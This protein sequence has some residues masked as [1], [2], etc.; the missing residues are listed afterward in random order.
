MSERIRPGD[1]SRPGRSVQDLMRALACAAVVSAA[2]C[3]LSV[4]AAASSGETSE[5]PPPAA[6]G[7]TPDL[8]MSFATPSAT[9]VSFDG[10]QVA[11]VVRTPLMEGK[12]SEWVSRIW[13]AAAD[14]SSNKQFTRGETSANAPAFSPD[15]RWLAFTAARG[16]EAGSS[17]T[18]QIWLLPM[19]GGEARQLTD[20]AS[21]VDAF[22]WSPD[23]TRIA[24]LTGDPDTPQEKKKK[25][26]KRAVIL[27]D[28]D[29]KMAR[30]HVL[31]VVSDDEA[32]ATSLPLTAGEAYVTSF[33]WS[34]DGTRIVFAHQPDPRTNTSLMRGDLSVVSVPDEDELARLATEARA[35]SEATRSAEEEKA[36]PPADVEAPDDAAGEAA[37]QPGP[38]G[39]TSSLVSLGGVERNPHWSPDGNW[40]VFEG[41]GDVPEPIGLADLYVVSPDGS[42]VR[43]LTQT[44]DRNARILGWSGDSRSVFIVENDG[45]SRHILA[46][47][48]MTGQI[49]Q[50]TTGDGIVGA[51]ALGAHGSRVAF[52]WQ[53]V[54]T[55]PEVF[56]S[57]TR[58]AAPERISELNVDIPLPPMGR[59]ELLHWKAPDGTP[60]EGLLTLPVDGPPD[61]RVPLILNVHGG[62]GGVFGRN[63]TGGPGLYMIQF[64]AQHGFAVLRPNPRGSTGYGKEFRY[65]NF[66]DWGY[67]DLS[68]LLA[69]VDLLIEQEVA[70]PDRLFLMG[71]SYGGYM[72]SF[73]VTRTDR[74][75][76]AS[77]GAGLPDLISMVTTTDVGDYLVAHMGAEYWDDPDIYRRHS[78][79]AHISRVVTPTQVMHGAN[80]RR[81]PLT[82]GIEFYRSLQRRGVPTEMV[83]YPRTPHG[84]REP[85]LLMDVSPRI[86][87]WFEKYLPETP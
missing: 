16:G 42:R 47:P 76:A 31:R 17:P 75:K 9:A 51:A 49:R 83:V 55:P 30:L 26:E 48:R 79:I 87:A 12:K 68:D 84:P 44:P 37:D 71:W 67:G 63:F 78:A 38:V 62:P 74:F 6:P 14:G 77:M 3:I 13:V 59:T 21:S 80:D 73:A 18:A 2:V 66:R 5:A 85:K 86:L 72:T 27:V 57:S 39:V 50:V 35:E 40:I 10:R 24:F 11:Y 34:S 52:S 4:P 1:A 61:Q 36:T 56:V 46:V 70:D 81:V 22:R 7:W 25:E 28:S 45:M 23:G 32:P 82:Q 43:R 19:S 53:T 20:V 15:G 41:T 65:A 58:R 69:G 8:C 33:D 54:D 64:F 60:V 29:F